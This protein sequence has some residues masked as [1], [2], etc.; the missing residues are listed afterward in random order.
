MRTRL[1][2]LDIDGTLLSTDG[3]AREAFREALRTTYGTPGP[4]DD[5][6]FAGKT[7]PQI[8]R[9]LLSAAGLEEAAIVAGLDDLWRRYLEALSPRLRARPPRLCEGV[10]ALLERIEASSPAVVAGLLTGNI[11]DGARLKLRAAGLDFE[12]FPVGAFGC[13]SADRRRLPEVAMRRA[14]RLLDQAVEPT[15]V[16]VVGDTP[17]DIDCARRCGA[18]AVA[19]A[20]GVYAAAELAPHRPD[21]LL[22]SLADLEEVWDVLLA[23]A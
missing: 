12:R 5:H 4:I 19:V 18:R 2:L 6:P 23:S 7:D 15:S 9:E 20:T 22:D 3:E 11:R 10:T 8:A 1:V 17:A 21:A 16:V 13:D 14:A